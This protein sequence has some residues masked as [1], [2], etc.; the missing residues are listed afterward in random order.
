MAIQ[1]NSTIKLLHQVPLNPNQ[2]DTL[3][4]ATRTEQTFYFNSKVV[5]TFPLNTY[6]RANKGVCRVNAVADELYDINYM[7]FQNTNY[8]NRW[9]YAFVDGVDYVNDNAC[10][11]RYTLDPLQTWL[12]DY[13]TDQCFIERC[14]TRS[15]DIGEHIE[16]ESFDLGELVL[17]DYSTF[18]EY[19]GTHDYDTTRLALAYNPRD[20]INGMMV[21]GVYSANKITCWN[22]HDADE[23]DA[24][25]FFLQ[26]F[27]SAAPDSITALYMIPNGLSY[28]RHMGD[29]LALTAPFE[30]NYSI[31]KYTAGMTLD[32]YTP[33]NQKMFTFPYNYLEV[34][35]NCGQNMALRYEFFNGQAQLNVTAN[36][37]YP[38][39][40]VCMPKNYKGS[41]SDTYKNERVTI[42]GFPMCSWGIDAY[43][44]WAAQN[45]VPMALSTGANALGAIAGGLAGVNTVPLG[46]DALTG[47][48]G[49]KTDYRSAELGGIAS[50]TSVANTTKKMLVDGYKASISADISGG[51]FETGNC[52]FAH[53]RMQFYFGRRSVNSM[54][55]RRIDDFFTMYGY[56]NGRVEFPN[57]YARSRYTYIKTVGCN[58][59]GTLPSEDAQYIANCYDRG[60]R[61]WHDHT[62][63]GDYTLPNIPLEQ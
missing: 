30:K 26:E 55:A 60:I 41:G 53:G 32:G 2:E 45:S 17:N 52:D 39:E 11:V 29:S 5:R 1:P 61:F 10:E 46:V 49:Y 4:F 24:L 43:K 51:S 19:A 7:M 6:Q 57:I 36:A 42:K 27:F 21:E 37:T 38:V 3:W 22:P 16:P 35:N 23:R 12:L 18:D 33:K 8:S 40:L 54:I 50:A 62:H 15:D 28:G 13:Q 31:P 44:A 48:M 59:Y 58:I 47:L 63:V 14:H 9:F 56:A 20:S 34:S 25:D